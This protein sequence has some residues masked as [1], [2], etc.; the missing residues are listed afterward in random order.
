MLRFLDKHSVSAGLGMVS[1]L[2]L[3]VA[4][5][6]PTIIESPIAK[7]SAT[8][9]TSKTVLST[10]TEVTTTTIQTAITGAQNTAQSVNSVTSASV[11]SLSPN[12][13]ELSSIISATSNVATAA[14]TS[15][16]QTTQ[17]QLPISA[18]ATLVQSSTN[19]SEKLLFVFA[20]TGIN[21]AE[22]YS[23]LFVILAT[24]SVGAL[25]IALGSLLVVKRRLNSAED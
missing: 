16:S 23:S 5:S 22:G 9:A 24:L 21:S 12:V 11:N 13:T 20:P 10:T 18:E 1:A 8:S 17:T 14:T 4:L 25:I 19:S 6:W 7:P 2:V 3:L 15:V